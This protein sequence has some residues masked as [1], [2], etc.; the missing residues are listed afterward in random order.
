MRKRYNDGK[1]KWFKF[2]EKINCQSVRF[3]RAKIIETT[4]QVISQF[5]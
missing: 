2:S 3:F 1:I 5:N 4:D